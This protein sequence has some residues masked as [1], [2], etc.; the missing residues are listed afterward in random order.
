MVNITIDARL[1]N[2]RKNIARSFCRLVM[3]IHL[4]MKPPNIRPPPKPGNVTT[5]SDN[6]KQQQLE[7]QMRTIAKSGKK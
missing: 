5:P 1:T 2:P 6:E 3:S 4:M 7:T